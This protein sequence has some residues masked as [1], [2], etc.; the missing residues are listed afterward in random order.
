MVEGEVWGALIAGTDRADHLPAGA[1][2]RVASFAELIAT[3]VSNATARSELIE[4]RARIIT[5]ADAARQ[6]LTRDLHDGAQQHFVNTVINLQLAEQKWSSEPKRSHELVHTAGQQASSG[7]ETLRE[8]AAG[9]HPAILTNRGLAAALEALTTR[10]SVPVELDISG[11][12]LPASLEASV[13]FFCSEALT[14]V[15]KHSR[16]GSARVGI[17]P[18]GDRLTVEVH[19]DGLGGATTRS[20]GSGLLGLYDRIGALGGHLEV[21]SPA[22]GGTALRAW[23]PLSTDSTGHEISRAGTAIPPGPSGGPRAPGEN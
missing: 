18:E 2:P 22:G 7:L 15:V 19:D 11:I 12:R 16:A 1:E 17:A 8:L 20:N 3:S 6:R 10:L 4:S 5:A 9:V 23:I 13:Y 21:S 14:N